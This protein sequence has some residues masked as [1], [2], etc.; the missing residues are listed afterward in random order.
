MRIISLMPVGHV[1]RALLEPL[2]E[3]LTRCLRVA[4]SIQPD[5]LEAEFAFNPQRRQY[6]STEILKKIVQ[7]PFTDAWKVLG[8]TEV[9]LYIPV[10]TFVFGEA[11]LAHGGAVVSAHRLHQQFYGMPPDPE[12][13]HE[14]LL[15]EA[16][17]E[18]GHTYGLRHCPDYNCVMSSSNG[19]ERIDLKSAGFCPNCA[20]L[21]PT[22]EF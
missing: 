21:V 6:H 4:C 7:K 8:V 17:H 5:G 10:L 1:D 2:A 16:L 12:L 22:D 3:G 13:L 9:D 15:K 14:R 20:Q 19:V 11:Q 18:L